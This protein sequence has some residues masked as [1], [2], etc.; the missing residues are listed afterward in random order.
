MNWDALGAAAELL[1]AVG[2]IISLLYLGVQIRLQ[3]QESR[4][5]SVSEAI[6]QFNDV[7]AGLAHNSDLTEIWVKGLTDYDNLDIQEKVRFSSHV[8]RVFRVIEGLYEY[9]LEGRVKEHSWDAIDRTMNEMLGY[10]GLRAWWHARSDW[11]GTP[12]Q[13]YIAEIVRVEVPEPNV[14]GENRRSI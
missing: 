7:L 10:S 6:R 3:N 4:L 14:Y 2:V 12:F 8:G 1:G 5:N 9:N 11:Y 13:D